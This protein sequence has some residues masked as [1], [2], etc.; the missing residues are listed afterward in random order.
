MKIGANI[1]DEYLGRK[2]A[3]GDDK[4]QVAFFKGFAAELLTFR[5]GA[6]IEFQFLQV[7]KKLTPRE[8][9]LLRKALSILWYTGE[10]EE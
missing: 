6:D 2:L 3:A 8:Q 9:E 4:T 5:S 7:T 10:E 1:D